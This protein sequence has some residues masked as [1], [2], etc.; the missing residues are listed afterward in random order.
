[1][2]KL[3]DIAGYYV[4]PPAEQFV[5]EWRVV[6]ET[7]GEKGQ[8]LAQLGAADAKALMELAKVYGY[9]DQ[10]YARFNYMKGYKYSL[11]IDAL[12]RHLIAFMGGEDRDPESGL[13]HT[14]HA[15]WHALTLTAFLLNRVGE[16][17]RWPSSEPRP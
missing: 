3:S 14:A 10:K 13:L 1:M 17:D 11:S 9:G 16:D 7:G 6:S 5:G 15:A 8:K 2:G 4:D 12:L